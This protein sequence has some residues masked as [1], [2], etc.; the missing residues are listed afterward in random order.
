MFEIVVEI[1]IKSD[2][3]IPCVITIADLVTFAIITK[4]PDCFLKR[5]RVYR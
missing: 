2:S 3:E 1:L 4:K 5:R